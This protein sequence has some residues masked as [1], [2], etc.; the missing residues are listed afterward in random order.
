MRLI[1]VVEDEAS[2]R[3]ELADIL[4]DEGH[5]VIFAENGLG[6]LAAVDRHRPDLVIS[7][8]HMPVMDGIG[9][10][11]KLRETHPL[12]P[13]IAMTETALPE[14]SQVL[15]ET[16]MLGAV[17]TIEKPLTRESVKRV[18]SHVL[19]RA[20]APVETRVAHTEPSG[21][22][23]AVRTSAEPRTTPIVSES[24][25]G[26]A[27]SGHPLNAQH[28]TECRILVVDDERT[29]VRSLQRILGNAGYKDVLPT[30]DPRVALKWFVQLQPDV[31]IMDL[32]MPH[33]DGFELL[34][35][36]QFLVPPEN[37]VPT[38]VLTADG[39]PATR[40]RALASGA[41]D[42][43]TKPF[44]GS[45]VLL[46][47][48]NLL[49]TRLA[50]KA[51]QAHAE[52]LE[53][54]VRARTQ[55]L[56]HAQL[57]IVRRLARAAE[58]RDDVTG[59]HAWRVGLLTGLLAEELG[60]GSERAKTLRWAAPLHDVGK[61]AIPDEILRKPGKLTADEWAVMRRHTTL[62]AEVLSGGTFPLLQTAEII[63]RSHHE[64]WD[65]QG[66]PNGLAGEEIPLIGRI[67][68]VAD[69]FDSLT[70]VRPYKPAMPIDEAIALI[71][72]GRGTHFDPRVV[73]AF[74]RTEASGCLDILDELVTQLSF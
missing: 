21:A 69:V 18:V 23:M 68:A 64:R 45:E 10:L 62:G 73:D 13:V 70:H 2:V 17:G 20:E 53:D 29:N 43:V 54:M 6:A 44:D 4:S 15:A 59:R 24:K 9:V 11:L 47:L 14:A 3:R 49:Q 42:Y 72:V 71:R 16:M 27:P 28:P 51:L 5:D 38:L 12:I 37:Y 63:A 7:D 57:E 41:R 22:R 39:S 31:F 46:R 66:Y 56:E 32:H 55:K 35:R 40:D 26:F 48:R 65:G 19:D 67:V 61:I 60:L 34:R 52:T 33:M 8:V 74:D 50:H 36:L 25:G 1:L 58:Y 30:T